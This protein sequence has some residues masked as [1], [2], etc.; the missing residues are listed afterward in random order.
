M[1][2]EPFTYRLAKLLVR[3]V[4]NFYFR[5]IEVSGRENVPRSGPVIFA[6][7]HPQSI[8]DTLVLALSVGRMVHYIAHSG[9]FGNR[10]KA[11]FLESA[12]VIP[13]YRPKD[14]VAS[15][16]KNV[17]TFR[18]CR[19]VLEGGGTLG[20]FPEGTSQDELRVQKFRTGTA[21]IALEA[22]A[23]NAFGLGVVIVPVGL[24]FESKRRLRSRVLVSIGPPLAVSKYRWEYERDEVAGV[25][26]LTGELE[27]L[28]R[29]RVVSLERTELSDLV[30]EIQRTY[31]ED[32]LGRRELAIPGGS[33]FT[34]DQFV[35]REIA[36]A[37][38]YYYEREPELIG[39]LQF[40]LKS[41]RRRRGKLKISDQL[42]QAESSP[43]V[44][45]ETARIVVLGLAGLLPASY[46]WLWNFLPYKVTGWLAERFSPDATKYHWFQLSIGTVIY[47]LYYP[48]LLWFAHRLFGLA[49]MIG[50]AASLAPTGFFARW[51]IAH[52][53]REGRILRY[54]YL[55]ASQNYYIQELKRYRRRLIVEMDHVLEDYLEVRKN[56]GSSE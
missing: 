35:A 4:L 25:R 11:A 18:A 51:Y 54:A 3:F 45:W 33:R 6:S 34:K 26:E 23:K 42:L 37:I 17:E 32:L 38:D 12:G 15:Q 16:E 22:E 19:A 44:R 36:R 20:I 31:M 39:R 9:L 5:R 56:E 52:M 47:L 1:K 27:R 14:E 53:V 40:L 8:T 2:H 7:N 41:Y 21:R 48:P 43:S 50:F 29:K 46:G 49:W 24:T 30:H 13:V 28:V 55:S 10:L